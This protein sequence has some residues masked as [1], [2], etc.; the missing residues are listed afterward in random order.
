MQCPADTRPAARLDE[1]RPERDEHDADHDGDDEAEKTADQQ[2]GDQHRAHAEHDRHQ[3]PHRIVAGMEET[4]KRP[5]DQPNQDQ[6][7][8]VCDH[9]F[10]LP[11][12]LHGETVSQ[13]LSDASGEQAPRTRNL[14]A[15]VALKAC[16]RSSSTKRPFPHCSPVVPG[17]CLCSVET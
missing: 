11:A 8:D 14:V 2:T 5:H 17:P 10:S 12:D 7:D 13:T 4:T 1:A 16:R 3:E 6:A 15:L 9:A